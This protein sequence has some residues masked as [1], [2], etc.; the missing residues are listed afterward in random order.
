MA[1]EVNGAPPFGAIR[2]ELKK[3]AMRQSRDG[4]IIS[5]V[6]HPSDINLDLVQAPIGTVYQGALME[7]PQ[8]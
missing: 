1:E 6:I 8:P 4:V 3:Y 5:F 2:L 7:D